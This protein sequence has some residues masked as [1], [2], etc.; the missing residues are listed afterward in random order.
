MKLLLKKI[1]SLKFIL[2]IILL[3]VS[4]GNNT[5]CLLCNGNGNF[6]CAVCKIGKSNN[7]ICQ[8]CDGNGNSICT[9]C[10]GTGIKK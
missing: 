7:Q 2:I 8:F 4:C 1:V 5:N 9:L 10:D 3:L 6:P